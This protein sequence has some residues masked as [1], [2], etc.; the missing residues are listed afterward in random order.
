VNRLVVAVLVGAALA[1]AAF[2]ARLDEM[3]LRDSLRAVNPRL[4]ASWLRDRGFPEPARPSADSQG[5]GVVGR[6][7]FG[8]AY[9]VDCRMTPAETLIAMGR[10]SGVSLLRFSRSDTAEF[11][12]LSD[13]NAARV[14]SRVRL[15]DTLLFIGTGA[16]VEAY[17]I[18]DERNPTLLNALL[19]PTNDFAVS[20]SLLYIMGYDD[21]FKVYSIADPAN[22]RRLGACRDSGGPVTLTGSTAF[23]G[24]Q[25]GLHA[26]D[27]SNPANPH[28]VGNWGTSIIGAEA[29]GNICCVTEYDPDSVHL[30][31]LDVSN[32]ANMQQLS[33]LWGAGGD[34]L[35]ID[36]QY[37]YTAGGYGFQVLDIVDSLNPHIV[38]RCGLGSYKYGVWGM[39]GFDRAFVA[40]DAN[41]LAVMNTGDP[42]NPAPDSFL[43]A[44]GYTVD[45]DVRGRF[46]YVANEVG[47]LKILDVLDPTLPTMIGELDSIGTQEWS[48]SVVTNDSFAFMGWFNTPFFRTV[49]VSDPTRPTF[50][51]SCDPFEFAQD[52]V[53]RDSLVYC[54][55]NYKFQVVNV[56]R[57]RAPVVVGTCGLPDYTYEMDMS[58][59][60]AF[61]ANGIAGLQIV[62]VARPATPAVIGE[63]ALPNGA[64]GIAVVDT[65]AYVASGNLYIVS[66]AEPTSPYLIDSV[67]LPTFG[68]SVAAGDSLLFVGSSG[69]VYGTGNDIRLFDIRNPVR[70]ASVG[71]IGAPDMVRRLAWVGPYLYAACND[72]G[73]LVVE[74][75]AVGAAEPRRGEW[76]QA[77]KGAS[78]VR[79]VLDLEVG[80]RQ[81]TAY[82]AELLD[83]SGRK[84]LDLH[85]GA[86]DVRALAPGVYFI[87]EEP[88]AT[89]LKPQAI[90]KVILTR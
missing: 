6:W 89:S 81:K 22:P 31:L 28:R 30:Y 41:G 66:V 54:A 61:I 25:S 5:L 58:D 86:N 29:R 87:R 34:A 50:A 71:S 88:Q 76:K 8:P 4:R 69:Y 64:I 3:V 49:N 23:V 13:I 36:G 51:G 52:M 11:Q 82:R 90:R 40:N 84:V 14:I 17:R 79:G 32:P 55:E 44:A 19:T 42:G 80:S 38:G 68:W 33:V 37:V 24:D 15:I 67:V 43:W 10:G 47:G 85:P 2:G 9:D 72:A 12:L 39:S 46:I 75:T 57:P 18:S 65:F 63:L 60:L 62:D 35:F 45:L 20:E 1:A 70:P 48:Y 73:V 74:T 27:V 16:G 59:T 53:L 7:S 56:A 83:V 78:V 21:S 26:I 77:R